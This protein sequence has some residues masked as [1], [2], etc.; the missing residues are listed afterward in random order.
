M[1]LLISSLFFCSLYFLLISWISFWV[2]SMSNLYSFVFAWY[3]FICAANSFSL[4]V[5]VVSPLCN[6]DSF[7]ATY[8]P[9]CFF[10]IY[11][12]SSTCLFF[13]WISTSFSTTC[14]V[15]KI[16]L[17]W[18]VFI[19]YFISYTSGSVPSRFLQ[20]WTLRGFSSSSERAL[21]LSFYSINSDWRSKI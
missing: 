15:L 14:S 12:I 11:R 6:I 13:W 5:F 16:S 18:S 21:T 4:L 19:F 7:Y 3:M 1:S 8:R 9:G 10:I 17:F 2:L 20:R